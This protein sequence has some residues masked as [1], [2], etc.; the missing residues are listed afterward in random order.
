MAIDTH[1][2]FGRHAL[3]SSRCDALMDYKLNDKSKTGDCNQGIG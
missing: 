1:S 3:I 2:R